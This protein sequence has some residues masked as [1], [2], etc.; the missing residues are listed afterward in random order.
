[1]PTVYFGAIVNDSGLFVNG[2]MIPAKGVAAVGSFNENGRENG[3]RTNVHRR[4]EPI[5]WSLI[6]SAIGPFG[7]AAV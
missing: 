4:G 3:C 6:E 5:G 1:L 2:D 7:K